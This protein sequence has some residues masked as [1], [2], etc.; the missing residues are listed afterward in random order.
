MHNFNIRE[1]ACFDEADRA[2]VYANIG[3]LLKQA[4]RV[5]EDAGEKDVLDAFNEMVQEDLPARFLGSFGSKV[6][7]PYRAACLC[8]IC[9]FFGEMDDAAASFLLGANL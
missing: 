1:A 5:A 2:V 8:S 7:L 4:G 6:G 3:A 9:S